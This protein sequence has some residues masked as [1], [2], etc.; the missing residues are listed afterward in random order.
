MPR[1]EITIP[2]TIIVVELADV[3]REQLEAR[4]AINRGV[5][6]ALAYPVTVR[7][8]KKPAKRKARA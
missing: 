3:T 7:E 8:I 4:I 6:A 5:I 1:F 2:R